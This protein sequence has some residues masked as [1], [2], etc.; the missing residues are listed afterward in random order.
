MG[1][2]INRPLLAFHAHYSIDADE[3]PEDL[4]SA[5]DI[6]ARA[7]SHLLDAGLIKLECALPADTRQARFVEGLEL[8]HSATALLD[9]SAAHHDA[10]KEQGAKP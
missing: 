10:A 3:H 7:A 5:G 9:M 2:A 8:L 1:N 6:L 4:R